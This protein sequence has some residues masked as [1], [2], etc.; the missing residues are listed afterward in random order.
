MASP[1]LGQVFD[2]EKRSR[3]SWGLGMDLIA[4]DG[5][6]AGFCFNQRVTRP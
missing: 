3:A 5:D 6:G 4:M 2:G 1:Y